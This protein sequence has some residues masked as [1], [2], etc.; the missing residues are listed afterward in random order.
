MSFLNRYK[1]VNVLAIWCVF[2]WL[3]PVLWV[4]TNSFKPTNVINSKVP[5]FLNFKPT[6][7]HYQVIFERFHI[8][9]ALF[10]SLIVVSVSTLI[11]MILALPTAYAVARMNML[12]GD[13][14]ALI[15]LSLRFLPGVVIV[16]PYFQVGAFFSLLDSKILLITVYVGMGLPFAVWTLRGFMM[17]I[18]KEI[19]EA[20]RLDGLSWT[21]IIF[22]LILPITAP[23][24]AVT[25]IFTFVFSWN[26]F[27]FAL[28][29][30]FD[31]AQTMPVALQ[32]TID[33]YNVLWGALS[34]GAVIQLVPMVIV[35]FLLQR[36]IARGLALGAVK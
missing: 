30:T 4:T 6:L 36:H 28:L 23:G 35:V 5:V 29:L 31:Q 10:N 24:V 15:I 18:P 21:Q 16:I 9:D 19:E 7:E 20:A 32:K 25:A 13:M 2:V 3:S 22:R 34:A 17:D 11:V 1:L 14:W 8:G 27:L 33:V 26:E 12:R